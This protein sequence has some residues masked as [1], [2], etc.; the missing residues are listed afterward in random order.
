MM[1]PNKEKSMTLSMLM[2]SA[3]ILAVYCWSAMQ[4]VCWSLRWTLSLLHGMHRSDSWPITTDPLCMLSHRA[5]CCTA[6]SKM[7]TLQMCCGESEDQVQ[8][9]GSSA[10]WSEWVGALYIRLGRSR[11]MVP[12]AS[13]QG[14]LGKNLTM[15]RKLNTN[16]KWSLLQGAPLHKVIWRC[17]FLFQATCRSRSFLNLISVNAVISHWQVKQSRSWCKLLC[18]WWSSTVILHASSVRFSTLPAIAAKICTTWNWM[19]MEIGCFK[20]QVR[21]CP[22]SGIDFTGTWLYFVA[23]CITCAEL[24]C[25]TFT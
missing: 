6:S 14:H 21:T 13:A 12:K 8:G 9:C 2:Q 7:A 5:R 23:S 3:D 17:S 4:M 19:W 11:D 22:S 16:Y 18:Q 10:A 1:E 15:T 20:T 25:N 24:C